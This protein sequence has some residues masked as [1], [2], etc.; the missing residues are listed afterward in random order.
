[1]PA[2]QRKRLTILLDPEM[3]EIIQVLLNRA[4]CE[5]FQQFVR[6]AL[7][8]EITRRSNL[9]RPAKVRIPVEVDLGPAVRS[10]PSVAHVM[11]K[12]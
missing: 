12:K 10:L 9:P 11:A 2:N 4:E 7:A 8:K 5:N 3:W 1:M 6:R